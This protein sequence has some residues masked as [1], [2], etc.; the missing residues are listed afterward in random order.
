MAERY[1]PGHHRLFYRATAFQTGLTVSA[2]MLGPDDVW[3][4]E[5]ELEDVGNGLYRF[6]FYFKQEGTWVGLFYENGEKKV[7]QNFLVMRERPKSQNGNV[8]NS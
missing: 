5:F 8:L 1:P 6:E 3:S 2:K 4:D 7:S